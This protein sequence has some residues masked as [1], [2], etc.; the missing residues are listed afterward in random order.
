MMAK[1][2]G[3]GIGLLMLAALAYLL[4]AAKPLERA[5]SVCIYAVTISTIFNQVVISWTPS[6]CQDLNA[7]IPMD[8]A[9][10]QH[11]RFQ[12]YCP[13]YSIQALPEIYLPVVD[14]GSQCLTN[15]GERN[16]YGHAIIQR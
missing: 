5:P 12:P 7:T 4:L 3:F 13:T 2:P 8:H 14:Y 9:K 11:S 6:P 16:V 1:W 10:M 15:E